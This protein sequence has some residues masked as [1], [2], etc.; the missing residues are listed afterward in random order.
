MSELN[1]T[2]IKRGIEEKT[3]NQLIDILSFTQDDYKPEVIPIID[4]VLIER[5]IDPVDIDKYKQSYKKLKS[6]IDK[7]DYKPKYKTPLIVTVIIM[8]IGSF[9]W[10]TAITNAFKNDN[11]P[12]VQETGWSI[13]YTDSIKNIFTN[14]A[15]FKSVPEKYKSS[16]CNC[17][18]DKL[19]NIYPHRIK[20]TFTSA[21]SD[22]LIR[23][24]TN[25]VK[26]EI[27]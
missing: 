9:V 26:S 16:F 14:S 24:C 8:A 10:K 21:M 7:S 3:T 11:K 12:I 20:T 25:Q 17:Y 13:G 27:K 1:L 18:M 15:F 19:K 23:E 22:S 4:E 6:S 5:G 2:V